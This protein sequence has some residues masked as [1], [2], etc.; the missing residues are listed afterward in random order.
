MGARALLQQPQGPCRRI[1]AAARS[2]VPRSKKET[3]AVRSSISSISSLTPPPPPILQSSSTHT[4]RPRRDAER[5]QIHAVQRALQ[6]QHP[7]GKLPLLHDRPELDAR[8]CPR[9]AVRL[10]RG[11]P[12]AQVRGAAVSG[13]RRHRRSRQG[14]EHGRGPR[15]RVPEPHQGCGRHPPRDARVRRPGRDPRGGPRRPR[16]RHRHHHV[17]TSHQRPRVHE[18]ALNEDEEGRSARGAEPADG[19]S[20]QDGAGVR[21]EG[22]RVARGRE[23]DSQRDGAVEHDGRGLFEHVPAV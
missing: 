19:E 1:R 13:D 6:L 5:R 18:R 10:A 3:N 11:S 20:A 8:P 15:E 12:Q 23:G 22:D 9:R 16:G 2:I 21:R 7:R 14:R 4:G 17:R